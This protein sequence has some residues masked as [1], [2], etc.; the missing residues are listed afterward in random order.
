[1]NDVDGTATSNATGGDGGLADLFTD[2]DTDGSSESMAEAISGFGGAA[3]T[4]Q[5]SAA[6]NN[7]GNDGGSN[8]STSGDTGMGGES[9]AIGGTTGLANGGTSTGG[10]AD[11]GG[12]SGGA[13][14]AASNGAGGAVDNGSWGSNNGDDGFVTGESY[15][16]AAAVVDTSAFNQN[17]VMG[18]N[19]LG[20]TVDMTVV[21]GNMSSN[22]V[23]DDSDTGV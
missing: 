11:V 9:T 5:D 4:T 2:S 16:S 10:A 7:G 6:N 3:D 8:T 12:A 20:N 14:G 21:G 1:M 17:I 18:A 15:A 19:V 22:Y 13:G 23:G